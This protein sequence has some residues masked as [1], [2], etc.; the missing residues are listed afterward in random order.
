MPLIPKRWDTEGLS[1][2]FSFTT[3]ALPAY[4]SATASTVGAN[5]RQGAHHSAQ[6]STSTG[7][8]DDKTSFSNEAS[9]T[10]ATKSLINESPLIVQTTDQSKNR[11]PETANSRLDR[12]LV[13]RG[14]TS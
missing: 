9:L 8:S 10:S 11:K 12:T 5:M 13:P 2:T 6:K 3:R 4:F 7:R 14:R 1:S